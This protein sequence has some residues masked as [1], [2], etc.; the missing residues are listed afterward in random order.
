MTDHS[1]TPQYIVKA[2][3]RWVGAIIIGIGTLALIGW[4]GQI[5]ALVALQAEFATM[6]FNTAL[7][8]VMCGATLIVGS[9]RPRWYRIGGGAIFLLALLTLLQ[10]PLNINIGIDEWL[11]QDVFRRSAGLPYPG[12]MSPATAVNFMVFGL[13]VFCLVN[14]QRYAHLCAGAIAFM[15]LLA[16][17]S[18]LYNVA[19][20]YAVFLF[21]TMA[22]HTAISFLLLAIG[23][24]FAADRSPLVDLFISDTS[25]G[26][27]MRH[28]LPMAVLALVL[29]GFTWNLGNR[30]DIYGPAFSAALT[31]VSNICVVM[32][33]IA[34]TA[35][36]LRLL[37]TDLRESEERFRTMLEQ[38]AQGVILVDGN[39]RMVHVNPYIE[40]TFQRS[41]QTLL[42]MN[43]ERLLPADKR[44]IHERLRDDYL[45]QPTPRE[46]GKNRELEA[47]RKDGTVFPVEVSLSPV[48][49]AGVPYVVAF[50][51]DIT[52]RKMLDEQRR[53]VHELE[54]ELEKERELQSLKNRFVATVSHEFRTPLTIIHSSVQMVQRYFERLSEDD[55]QQRLARASEQILY[56]EQLLTEVLEASKADTG[57]M[58]IAYQPEPIDMP[59]FMHNFIESVRFTDEGDHLLEMSVDAGTLIADPQLLTP[60]LSNIISNAFKYSPD[61]STVTIRAS[62]DGGN[63]YFTVQDEG[64]GIPEAD[65][66]QLFTPFH[67]A[68][69]VKNITGTGL[70]LSI[71]NSY[72]HQ[73]GGQIN[74]HS[75]EGEGT[76]VSI[77]IPSGDEEADGDAAAAA[78]TPD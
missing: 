29:I 77:L 46:M 23:L 60:M 45:Q 13:G 52:Q 59:T 7:L 32:V 73:H 1:S 20:L 47:Q 30:F 15:S 69:N 8:F 72:V 3:P 66:E 57:T 22:L 2:I 70:G 67:R 16:M 9:R 21:S 44:H 14:A 51:A 35:R 5:R 62:K 39:G 74:I 28:L 27:T 40:D 24:F 38:A 17:A 78:D 6:K 12:R 76:T 61:H 34:W 71:V 55:V 42:G 25:G 53:Y 4:V 37:E 50:V 64:I 18:Y 68:E 54:V 36:D 63:W 26:Y 19:D 33:I 48:E 65:L 43:I 58:G 56:M 41:R 49:I 75:V 10:Y 31:I 11:L